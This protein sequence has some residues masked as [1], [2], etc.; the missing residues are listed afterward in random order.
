MSRRRQVPLPL[1]IES[2]GVDALERREALYLRLLH[3]LSPDS[4]I[5]QQIH[6][7]LCEVRL[8]MFNR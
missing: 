5:A 2:E 4:V 7:H 8:A 6:Q 3:A 1:W